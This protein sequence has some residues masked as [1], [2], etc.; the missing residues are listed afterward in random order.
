MFKGYKCG[1]RN[2]ECGIE[3]KLKS[4]FVGKRLALR[5]LRIASSVRR[6]GLGQA[7]GFEYN[8]LHSKIL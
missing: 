2:T 6:S 5:G 4:K 1:I 7:W 8:S 3:E